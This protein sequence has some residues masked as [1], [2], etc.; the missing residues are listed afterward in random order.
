MTA[1]PVYATSSDLSTALGPLYTT[2][3]NRLLPIASDMVTR[4]CLAPYDLDTDS[5]PKDPDKKE[6]CK[7]ATIAQVQAFSEWGEAGH[8]VEFAATNVM[9]PMISLDR[10]SRIP[11]GKAKLAPRALD[12]LVQVGLTTPFGA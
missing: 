10:G 3:L 5:T 7:R 1:F 12:Y 8:L 11:I 6:A 4:A 2:D 9:T